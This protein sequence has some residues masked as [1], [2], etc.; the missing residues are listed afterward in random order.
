M[1]TVIVA[2]GR[3]RAGA[4]RALFD[5]YA[6]RLHPAPELIEVEEKRKLEVR[7]RVARESELL[8]ARVPA[9]AC[10]IALDATGKALSSEAL[11]ERLGKL[12]D[13]GTGAVCFVIGGADGLAR[14]VLDAA[15]IVL[16]LGPMTWP[17]MLVRTML[18]EQVYRAEMILAGHPYHRAG[19]PPGR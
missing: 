8:L 14:A 16:S 4:E 17:H 11:A 19:P 13:G 12:R 6:K 15:D 5:D 2:V 3:F 1:K 10:L 7:D 18:A 9:G